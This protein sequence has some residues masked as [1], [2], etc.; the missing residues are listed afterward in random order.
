MLNR[1]WTSKFDF[2]AVVTHKELMI[3]RSLVLQTAKHTI[4]GFSTCLWFKRFV[5]FR[6]DLEFGGYSVPHPLEDRILVR[7]QAKRGIKAAEI[8]SKA[9]DDLELLFT[10]VRQNFEGSVED[11]KLRGEMNWEYECCILNCDTVLRTVSSLKMA[12]GAAYT[13]LGMCCM[14]LLVMDH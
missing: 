3:S 11:Y 10:S 1:T 4:F 2:Y 7:V 6:A 13:K 12:K 8:L 14:V 5:W 9:F